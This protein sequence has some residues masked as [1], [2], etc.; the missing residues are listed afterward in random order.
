MLIGGNAVWLGFL[1]LFLFSGKDARRIGETNNGWGPLISSD[2]IQCQ[3]SQ[4]T[5]CVEYCT[6]VAFTNLRW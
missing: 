6:C 4:W 2:S 1:H 3:G 5:A